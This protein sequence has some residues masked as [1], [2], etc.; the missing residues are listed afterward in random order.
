MSLEI[1]KIVF[2]GEEIWREGGRG[3][4]GGA[5]RKV[6]VLAIVRNPYAGAPWSE[7]LDDLVK[8]SA[9][10]GRMLGQR[11]AELLQ[12]PT[13][14]YGKAAAVGLG[15]EQEHANACL[16]SVFGDAFRE[17]V[18]GGARGCRRSPSGPP[19]APPSTFPSVTG[20]PFGSAP[21]MTPSP[22]QLRM[23]QRRT[24]SS[25]AWR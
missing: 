4:A 2:H 24:R 7:S 8:P 9:D 17:A 13:E 12:G 3:D 10:L 15:G 19:P 14:G 11:A 1:R 21:I 18:G 25:L 22:C 6:A 5:L 16:T 23:R 20:M